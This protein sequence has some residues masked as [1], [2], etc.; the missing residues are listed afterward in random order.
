M[1]PAA[2][3]Q[4]AQPLDGFDRAEVW[5]IAQC[6]RIVGSR[7]KSIDSG[8]G[9]WSDAYFTRVIEQKPAIRVAFIAADAENEDDLYLKTRWVIFVVTGWAGG[10]QKTRRRGSRH[11]IGAFRAVR[12]LAPALH[13]CRIPDVGLVRVVRAAN[14]WTGDIDKSGSAVFGISLNIDMTLDPEIDEGEF[15]D[16][17][18]IGVDW[19]LPRVGELVDASDLIVIPRGSL[20]PEPEPQ[21]SPSQRER[22]RPASRGGSPDVR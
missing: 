1:I 8:P 14:L 12:L 11:Q 19:N 2:A 17:L 3:Q 7:F 21:P 20:E 9:D 16:F 22:S 18:S 13:N 10:D 15:D 5:L 4:E 6:E